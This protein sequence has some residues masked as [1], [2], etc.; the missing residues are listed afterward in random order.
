MCFHYHATQTETLMS[1]I[2]WHWPEK[3]LGI[4]AGLELIPTLSGC[5]SD[6]MSFVKYNVTEILH[7]FLF[8][9]IFAKV[10]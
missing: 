7:I 5:M 1:L 2:L 10:F 3:T 4:W 9:R 8:F 6:S